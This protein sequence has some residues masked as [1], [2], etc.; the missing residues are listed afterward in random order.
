[1]NRISYAII[2]EEYG[3]PTHSHISYGLAAYVE[4]DGA[5]MPTILATVSNIT[6]RRADLE[7]LADLCNRLELSIVH[8]R[9]VVEDFMEH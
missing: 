1:M 2:Q 8:M 7:A 5:E 4:T 9:D 3:I 6:S